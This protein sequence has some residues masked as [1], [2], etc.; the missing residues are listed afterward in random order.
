VFLNEIIGLAPLV[1]G[2]IRSFFAMTE[3]EVSGVDLTGRPRLGPN[4]PSTL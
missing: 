2:A 3:P 1:A 4:S